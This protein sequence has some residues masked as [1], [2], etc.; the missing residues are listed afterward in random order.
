M[1]ISTGNQAIDH[2]LTEFIAAF[3]RAFPSRIRGYFLEGSYAD[4]SALGTSDVDLILVFKD[5]FLHET[6][7]R[8]AE[9]LAREWE[10]VG[11]IEFDISLHEEEKLAAGVPPTL[12]LGSVLLYGE[13]LPAT[14]PL[15]PVFEWG[16]ERTH[17]AYWLMNK[18]FGRPAVVTYPLDYP[19]PTAEFYGYTEAQ[20]PPGKMGRRSTLPEI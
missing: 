17:A 5:S 18:V 15:I 2:Q 10:R 3:E 19:N 12:K 9:Q 11:P 7:Q 4:Q 1:S 8:R 6:E 16:R 13:P 14:L 20:G